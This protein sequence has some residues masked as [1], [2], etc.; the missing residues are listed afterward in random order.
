MRGLQKVVSVRLAPANLAGGFFARSI[1][2]DTAH[3]ASITSSC[4]KVKP[5][6]DALAVIHQQRYNG[7]GLAQA[8]RCWPI[9]SIWSLTWLEDCDSILRTPRLPQSHDG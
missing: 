1:R 8:R 6:A 5:F 7:I 3:N 9:A 2:S 4:D